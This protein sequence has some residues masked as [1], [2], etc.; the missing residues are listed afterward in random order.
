MIARKGS[1]TRTDCP[2]RWLLLGQLPKSLGAARAFCGQAADVSFALVSL[3]RAPF[4]PVDHEGL[5]CCVLLRSAFS[6]LSASLALAPGLRRRGRRGGG[7]ATSAS[8]DP[9]SPFLPA[10]L[11]ALPRR[12]W[13]AGAASAKASVTHSWYHTERKQGSSI[14]SMAV[15]RC[16]PHIFVHR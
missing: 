9:D 8:P 7:R 3:A 4:G 14:H 11:V 1:I 5:A 6:L 2:L 12:L 15:G 16:N 13:P 10:T